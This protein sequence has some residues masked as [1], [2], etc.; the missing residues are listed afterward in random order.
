MFSMWEP[1]AAGLSITLCRH[2]PHLTAVALKPASHPAPLGEA[3]VR[4]A[5][6]TDRIA[7][8]Q[9]RVRISPSRCL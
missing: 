4:Q 2:F 3:H 8:R 9:E 1:G 6:L 5:E 7:I